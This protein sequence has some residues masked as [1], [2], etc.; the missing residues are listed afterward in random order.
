MHFEIRVEP[1]L[2]FT[3]KRWFGFIRSIMRLGPARLVES[4]EGR[5][6]NLGFVNLSRVILEGIA[7]LPRSLE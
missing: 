4:D 3:E 5:R 2:Y 6:E 7:L 1:L